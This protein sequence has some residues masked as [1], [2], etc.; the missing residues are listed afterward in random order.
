MVKHAPGRWLIILMACWVGATA[1]V[2]RAQVN[3]TVSSSVAITVAA[4]SN[5]SNA[6]GFTV[7]NTSGSNIT[8]SSINISATNAGIFSSLTLTGQVPGTAAVAASITSPTSSNSFD[9]SRPDAYTGPRRRL[10]PTPCG[11]CRSHVAC[12][13]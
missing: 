1:G 9:L 13:I 2:A 11:L 8:I 6:G 3:V 7:T 4:G 5:I 12:A 10:A